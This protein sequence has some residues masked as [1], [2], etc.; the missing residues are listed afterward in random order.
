[1]QQMR[2]VYFDNSATTKPSE[3]VFEIVQSTLLSQFG[4]PASLHS[5]GLQA[6]NSIIEAKNTLCSYIGSA[7]N[8]VTFTSGGTESNNLAVFGVAEAYKRS[9]R[10]IITTKAE[11]PSVLEPC[12]RLEELGFNVTYLNVD[13]KGYVNI[14]E[15][16]NALND[17]TTLVSIQHV[18]SETGTIQPVEKIADLIKQKN[19]KTM[20]HVDGVQAFGKIPVSLKKIDLYSASSHKVHGLKGFGLLYVKKGTKLCPLFYGGNQQEGTRSGTENTLG[21]LSFSVAASE[22]FNNIKENY[23]HVSILKQRLFDGIVKSAKQ[24]EIVAVVNGDFENGSAYIL[25]VSFLGIKGEVLLRFL[26]SKGIYV[27]TGS[28]CSERRKS[29]GV[30]K[31]YGLDESRARSAVRFSFSR[32]NTVDEVDYCIEML[33]QGLKYLKL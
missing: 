22:C 12:K 1:M 14:D 5:L 11:H 31:S 2:N 28:A 7:M 8:E 33:E 25:N 4:N 3:A 24:N 10:C 20:F 18:N 6:E 9:G 16:E 13:E 17:E 30:L 23:M 19:K 29:S 15:L 21:V 26:D 27:S 32:Y